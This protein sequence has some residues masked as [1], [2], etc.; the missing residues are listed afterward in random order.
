[1]GAPPLA[2][3]VQI[4]AGTRMARVIGRSA[5]L[6]ASSS[7]VEGVIVLGMH[8]SGTSVV[9]RLISLLGLA[10]CHPDDL[11]AGVPGNPRGH[12]ESK[13]LVSFDSRLLGELESTWFCPP[14][15]EPAEIAMRLAPHRARALSLL[16]RAHP[17]RPF[18][19]KDPRA[20][21][22]LPFWASALGR[23]VVH[24]I[25]A[26]HPMEVTESLE[27]RNGFSTAHGLALWERYSR[28][29]LLGSADRPTVLCTYDEVL[30]EPVGW[31]LRLAAFLRDLGVDVP[32]IDEQAISAFVTGGLRRGQHSWA[33]L[34][35][36]EEFPRSVRHWRWP[37]RRRGPT[38]HM[39]LRSWE[40][41]RRRR[42]RP[43]PRS[44]VRASACALPRP[45][46]RPEPHDPVPART[47]GRR[48]RL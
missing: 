6:R 10:L 17:V 47:R 27:H 42:R 11:L 22:L 23:R 21:L 33:Q 41:R 34:G 19:W 38:S 48:R 3:G 44:G 9:T 35:T 8:R 30:A 2:G 15:L 39:S 4:L 45:A 28:L 13:S 20:C 26:R 40:R 31:S 24:V 14:A 12:W 7:P 5:A 37:R 16:H 43:L 29:A 32:H 18:V 46:W 1:M 25:V 36:A